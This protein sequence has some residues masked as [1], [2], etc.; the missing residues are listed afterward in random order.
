[1]RRQRNNLQLKGK[2][3]VSAKILNEIE[4]SQFSDTRF[5]TMVTR[6]LNEPSENYKK[7]Q[8]SYKELSANYISMKK[9]IETINKSQE[10]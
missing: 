7:L 4:A 6:K 1:M 2:E 5:K 10:K 9:D 8:G 3:E